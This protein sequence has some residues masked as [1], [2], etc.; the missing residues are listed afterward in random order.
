MESSEEESVPLANKYGREVQKDKKR[1]LDEQ[2][3]EA[4]KL[5]EEN[6]KRGEAESKQAAELKK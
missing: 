6:E 5:K 1:V 2:E 3:K 4:A